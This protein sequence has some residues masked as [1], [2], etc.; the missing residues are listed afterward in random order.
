MFNS[1]VLELVI[2]LSFI[3]FMGSLLLSS[4]NEAIAGTFRLR[5]KHLKRS[6]ESLFFD[7]EWKNFIQTYIMKSP[8]IQSLMRGVDQYPVYIPASNFIQAIVEQFGSENLNSGNLETIIRNNNVLPASL[9]TVMLDLL[10]KAGNDINKFQFLCEDFYNSAMD[11]AS[12]WYKRKFRAI[13]LILGFS[14]A[15]IFN[16]DTIEIGNKSLKDNEKMEQTVDRIVSQLPNIAVSKYGATTITIKDTAGNL[17]V[18]QHVALDTNAVNAVMSD[19]TTRK[20]QF[21]NLKVYLQQNAGYSF[22]YRDANDLKNKWLHSVPEFLL[23]LVG[24]IVTAFAL[25]LGSNYW[26]E[27]INKAVNIRAAGKKPE[28]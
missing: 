21:N 15:A 8:H 28:T 19:T 23:K 9:K 6:L 26:F 14:L 1:P 20:N 2:L 3:Y 17:L 5:Q 22:G 13:L 7:A 27:L 10:A 11:R 12:G 16:L 25:Q 18:E 24:I 4:I